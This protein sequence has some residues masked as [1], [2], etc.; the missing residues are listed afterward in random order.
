MGGSGHSLKGAA[1]IAAIDAGSNAMRLVIAQPLS[2]HSYRVLKNER[3]ALRLGARVFT[4]REFASQ[5]LEQAVEVF[6]RFKSR[7]NQHD[8][9]RY[10]AVATSAT[11][12]ARN[13]QALVERVFRAT[14]I[15][16]EVID[17]FEEARLI[18]RAVAAELAGRAAPRLIVDLGGGSMQLSLLRGG[19]LERSASLSLGTVRLMEK[20]KVAEAL[21][22][23]QIRCIQERVNTQLRRFV[24]EM[25]EAVTSLPALSAALC[26]GNAE[27]LALLAPGRAAQG[28]PTLDFT[29]LRRK[30]R[31]ISSL[32]VAERIRAFQV[33]Q[34]RAEVMA[35]AAAVFVALGAAWNLRRALVPGVG[36]K[37]G[38]LHEVLDSMWGQDLAGARQQ[39]LL[40][41]TRRFA[42]NLGYDAPHCEKVGALAVSLFD[43][44]QPLHRMGREMRMI[45][46]LSALLHDIGHA[47]GREDHHKVGEF[48]VRHGE[49]PGLNAFERNMIACLVRYHSEAGPQTDHKIFASLA[50]PEKRQVLMLVALLRIADRLDGNHL[51][52]VSQVTARLAAGK[53]RLALRM[54]RASEL[55]RWNVSRGNKLFE[56][57]FGRKLAVEIQ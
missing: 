53:I 42:A 27:A 56:E 29:A 1:N 15:R 7:M 51:Q 49:I 6:R 8:V 46:Q 5:T 23:E 13:R 40:F 24:P 54:K 44:L 30:L 14:G 19:V 28:V 10:R 32:S 12:E 57:Q 45:L 31:R 50:A 20:F 3:A 37:E 38:A 2:S 39:D 36:V 18:R 43:Q 11:R 47:I 52:S 22:G 26:G 48:L 34:D 25:A 55:I 16:L 33:R 9:Q 21:S 4:E 35:I 17:G 41:V